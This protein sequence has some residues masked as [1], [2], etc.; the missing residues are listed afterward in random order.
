MMVVD[1][2]LSSG[3]SSFK[4]HPATKISKNIGKS[5][6]K[7]TSTFLRK[8]RSFFSKN[9]LLKFLKFIMKNKKS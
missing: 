3:R 5:F 8:M 9:I 6:L 7:T 2:W 4:F 1:F